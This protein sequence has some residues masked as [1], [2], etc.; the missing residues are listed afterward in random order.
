MSDFAHRIYDT[1]KARGFVFDEG[2]GQ[3]NIVY[4]EGCNGD[5]TPN[6]NRPNAFDDVR[7][8][9]RME[10]GQPKIINWWGATTQPG[11][12]LTQNPVADAR[13]KGAAIIETGQQRAWQ[14]GLHRGQYES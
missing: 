2:A 11:T 9:L 5:G 6:Q 8:V 13:T 1:M 7:L 12:L 14:V 10:A 4:V 3:I